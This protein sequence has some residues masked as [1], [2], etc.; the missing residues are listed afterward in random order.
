[1]KRRD[2]LQTTCGLFLAGLAGCTSK[3]V[4][5]GSGATLEDAR[6]A[7]ETYT[8]HQKALEDGYR[9]TNAC[10]EGLGTPFSNPNIEQISYDEPQALLYERTDSDDFELKGAEWFVPGDEVDDSENPP[11]LFAGEDRRTMDG[12]TEGH[13]PG[14]PRHYGVHAWL[15]SDNPNGTFATTNPDVGCSK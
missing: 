1:M 4:Q 6:L 14:Q 15:F 2:A 9:N 11:S 5:S 12:P 8:D 13:Y 3:A 7:L 10:V